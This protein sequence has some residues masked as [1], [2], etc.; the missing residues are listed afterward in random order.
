MIIDFCVDFLHK[1]RESCS[2]G[3]ISDFCRRRRALREAR[4]DRGS[5]Q[6]SRVGARY[7]DEKVAMPPKYKMRCHYDILG[8]DPTTSTTEDIKHAYRQK[9]RL[10]PPPP[11]ARH[12]WTLVRRPD[13]RHPTG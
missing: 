6:A 10:F 9:A 11:S 4:A 7:L 3:E 2:E 1:F 5:P 8:V 13:L 12:P